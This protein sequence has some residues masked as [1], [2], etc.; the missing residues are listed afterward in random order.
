[1]HHGVSKC[2]YVAIVIQH[3]TRM[4]QLKCLLSACTIV[5]HIIAQNGKIFGKK[6]TKHKNE[7]FY[8]FHL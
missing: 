8:N 4:R 6:I 3:A 7:F 1:M 2:V 5:F